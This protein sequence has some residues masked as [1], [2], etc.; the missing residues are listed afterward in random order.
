M[1]D[2]SE[3]TQTILWFLRKNSLSKIES[4][5]ILMEL[6]GISLAEAK[7]LVHFSQAWQ[8]VQKDDEKFQELLEKI[9]VK[10][11]Q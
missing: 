11:E 10:G 2:R 9:V 7:E 8:D 4:I 5:R 6:K 3:D 1:I